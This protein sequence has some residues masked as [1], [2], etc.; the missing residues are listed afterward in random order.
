[1]D[2]ARNV[3]SSNGFNAEWFLAVILTMVVTCFHPVARYF[4]AQDD[5]T[6][7]LRAST[8]SG[9]MLASFFGPDPGQFRPLTKT[10][11]F[12]LM[13]KAFG[14]NAVAY[15]GASI[16]FHVVNSTLVY[17][18]MRRLGVKAAAALVVTAIFALSSA[19]FHVVAW[20]SCI[21]QLIAM[22]FVLV[23]LLLGI[24]GLRTGRAA[25][26][27][28]SLAAYA[29]ALAS[30]EQAYAAPIVLLLVG[31]L[32]IG[33][34][35]GRLGVGVLVRRLRWHLGAMFLYACFMLAWKGMPQE[36]V[37]HLNL[38]GNVFVNLIVYLKWLVSYWVVLPASMAATKAAWSPQHLILICLIVYNLARK[39][40]S[41]TLLAL[42]LVIGM[43]LP[44]LLLDQHTFFLH[45]YL[46]SI[47]VLYLIALALN[48]LFGFRGVR[49]DVVQIP[50]LTILLIAVF[51]LSF[52]EI[53]QNI[54][55]R[56]PI[57]NKVPASFVLRRA[58]IAHQTYV[59]IRAKAGDAA[60][61]DTLNMVYARV[62]GVDAASWNYLNVVEALARGDAL[63]LFLDRPRMEVAF[64]VLGDSLDVAEHNG[65]RVFY[66]GDF[67][68][69]YAQ[70]ERAAI[71]QL[72]DAP[73]PATPLDDTEP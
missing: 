56:L 3:E 12:A 71:E 62:E 50:V 4:L 42:V 61:I 39:R 68:N 21:Q 43:L 53:R 17:V 9:G 30:M 6:L 48:D 19:F 2:N 14:L 44:V 54:T 57:S 16:A 66:F 1:M 31:A 23:T 10:A 37:Y 51:G 18:L 58:K 35:G 64:S 73:S 27:W 7:M 5:F 13:F 38:G 40:L 24:D 29:L 8:D 65:T 41:E 69:C 28:S 36:G 49:R 45:T 60:Q 63:K 72:L 46:P 11:Y 33:D 34:D 25:N 15:H 67:G 59:D 32:G 52:V 26:L 22:T 47:G 70:S 20:A 55:A